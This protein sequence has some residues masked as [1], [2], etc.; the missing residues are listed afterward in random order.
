M[1][2]ATISRVRLRD[3][4][5]LG[6][7]RADHRAAGGPLHGPCAS[8]RRVVTDALQHRRRL[9]AAPQS[10]QLAPRTGDLVASAI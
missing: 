10:G 7:F 2:D 8:R 1:P 5:R 6:R 4:T 3:L 9:V